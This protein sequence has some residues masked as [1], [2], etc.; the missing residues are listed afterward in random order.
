MDLACS[1]TDINET[2][3]KIDKTSKLICIEETFSD[4][5]IIIITFE[6]LV[7]RTWFKQKYT[8]IY[9]NIHK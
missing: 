6:D 7:F 9:R 5:I 4:K 1:E 3:K 8:E 2:K